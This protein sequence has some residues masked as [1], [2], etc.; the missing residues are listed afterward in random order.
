MMSN[1][2]CQKSFTRT[3]GTIHQNTLWLSDTQRFE[4]LRVLD[5]QLDD[6]LDFFNL[7]VK[8]SNHVIGRIWNL[9]DF[10]QRNQWIH[11]GR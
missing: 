7:L 4:D 3:W 2:S 8:T 10:H 1:C 11:F 5:W 9:F 6:F